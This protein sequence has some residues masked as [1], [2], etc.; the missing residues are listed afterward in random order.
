MDEYR[1]AL[2]SAVDAACPGDMQA[3]LIAQWLLSSLKPQILAVPS[4]AGDVMSCQRVGAR[5]HA[6]INACARHRAAASGANPSPHQ[7]SG[8][9]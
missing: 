7:G 6:T 3:L 5:P 2:M 4:D 8:R 1:N 9:R